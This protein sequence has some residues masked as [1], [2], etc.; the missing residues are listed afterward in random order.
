V[1]ASEERLLAHAHHALL[2]GRLGKTR[3][4]EIE[5]EDDDEHPEHA[6]DMQILT[7]NHRSGFKNN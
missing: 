5:V 2:Y 6:C 1:P 4:G 7:K 3:L